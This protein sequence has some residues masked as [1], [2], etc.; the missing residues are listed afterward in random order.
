VTAQ[1]IA[2]LASGVA[3]VI[4][5]G[6]AYWAWS[7]RRGT[8]STEQSV[9]QAR[10]T[11]EL[12]GSGTNGKSV[13]SGGPPPVPPD[14]LLEACVQG[15]CVLFAGAG[16]TAGL[17]VPTWREALLKVVS[18]CQETYPGDELW[19]QLA[20]E[21]R[22]AH[23]DL[24]MELLVTRLGRE[25]LLGMLRDVIVDSGRLPDPRFHRALRSVRFAGVISSGWDGLA[26]ELFADRDPV[27]LAPG[28]VE[29]FGEA[30]LRRDFFVL[31]AYGQLSA[32]DRIL[33]ADEL[34]REL[35][36][37]PE[38]ARFLRSIYATRTMLFV[39]SGVAGV[40]EKIENEIN[41]NNR[42]QNN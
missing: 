38:Y 16:L 13:V 41:N 12:A 17:G 31:M 29:A 5:A 27:I 30:L 32:G 7:I 40:E 20:A 8:L 23:Y 37:R 18:L 33:T 26:S 21:A 3:T 22:D 2:A 6:L 35:D 34:R 14:P 4:A 39:G 28:S 15:E 24:V 25:T 9:N 19:S 36:T 42:H 11:I 10:R 1:D